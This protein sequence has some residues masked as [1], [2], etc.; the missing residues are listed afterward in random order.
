M[1][2]LISISKLP[3]DLNLLQEHRGL[4]SFAYSSERVNQIILHSQSQSSFQEVHA[5][6]FDNKDN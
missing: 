3:V 6:S 1:Y 2:I 5:G 4:T